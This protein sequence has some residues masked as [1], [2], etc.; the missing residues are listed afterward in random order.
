VTEVT[1]AKS[2]RRYRPLKLLLPLWRANTEILVLLGSL[3]AALMALLLLLP[4][5]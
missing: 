1:V 2:L 3:I 4:L 5:L